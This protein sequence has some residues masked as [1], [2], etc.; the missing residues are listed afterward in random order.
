MPKQSWKGGALLAP[1]PAVLV[2]CGSMEKPNVLT[3][4]WTGIINTQPPKTYISIRPERYSYPL[5]KKSGEFVINLT[6]EKLVRAVD[7][8]GVRSGRENDKFELCNLT[9]ER[10]P[11]LKNCP[12]IAESPVSLEC[13]VTGETE[14][15]SHNLLLADIVAVNVDE[16]LLSKSGALDMGKAGLLAFA[17]G[18]YYALGRNLGSFGFSVAKKKTSVRN[19]ARTKPGQK[20]R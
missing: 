16:A 15:G 14:L 10:A 12:M 9:A 20:K 11:K 3:I 19:K 5:I 4:A 7:F 1:L 6:T 17:H 18:Q 8:C 13:R 2:S